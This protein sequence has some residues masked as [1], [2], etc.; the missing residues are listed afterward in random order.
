MIFWQ[1]QEYLSKLIQNED[2]TIYTDA[3]ESSMQLYSNKFLLSAE[4]K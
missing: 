1:V 3:G 2:P 4:F